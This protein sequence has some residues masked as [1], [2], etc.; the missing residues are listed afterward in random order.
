M[1][2]RTFKQSYILKVSQFEL[3]RPSKPPG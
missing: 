3:L 2:A 1:T